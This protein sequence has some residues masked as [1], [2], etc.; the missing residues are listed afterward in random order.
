MSSLRPMGCE[1]G[2]SGCEREKATVARALQVARSRL[3]AQAVSVSSAVAKSRW[4]KHVVYESYVPT[5]M[6]PAVSAPIDCAAWRT[7]GAGVCADGSFSYVLAS[8]ATILIDCAG[9]VL[10]SAN[11][12]GVTVLCEERRQLLARLWSEE[13]A[14]GELESSVARTLKGILGQLVAASP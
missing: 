4:P 6:T 11:D 14:S 12:R 13:L 8:N 9:R 10:A 3:F 2:A 7:R 5:A 1:T